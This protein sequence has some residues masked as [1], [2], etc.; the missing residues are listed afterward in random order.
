M[1]QV[2]VKDRRGDIKGWLSSN[3]RAVGGTD[4]VTPSVIAIRLLRFR[5]ARHGSCRHR[6]G[7]R[8][9]GLNSSDL[10]FHGPGRPDERLNLCIGRVIKNRPDQLG[11]FLFTD[12]FR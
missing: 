3:V 10:F 4:F 8:R 2:P 5:F 1:D 11:G 12:F 6:L 7:R 9:L